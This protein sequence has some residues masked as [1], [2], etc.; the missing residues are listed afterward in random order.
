MTS[1]FFRKTKAKKI[2]SAFL[3]FV[4]VF[5]MVQCL[6]LGS[7]AA[8]AD[9]RVV[10]NSTMDDWKNYFGENVLSTQNA[11]KVWTD[12]S[13]LKEGFTVGSGANEVT[14]SLD[15]QDN[16]SF[17]VVLS[18][19]ASNAQVTGKTSAPLDTMLVL[20]VSGS[21]NNNS[22]NNDAVEDLVDAANAAAKKLFEA[23][24]K[25]RVGVVL[26]SSSASVLLPLGSYTTASDDNYFNY[27]TRG[28]D[29]Y[30]SVDSDVRV[31]GT[32]T[33]PSANTTEVVGA[34]YVQTGIHLAK[35]QFVAANNQTTVDG[36]KRQPVMI[37]MSDGNPT[38]STTEYTNPGSHNLGN[39]QASSTSAA[40]GFVTQLTAAYA[41]QQVKE[42][43]G[44][45]L[46]LYTLGFKVT[47]GS[48]AESVLNPDESTTAI[49]DL[50][51]E[52]DNAAVGG[53]VAIERSGEWVN[54]GSFWNPNYEYV[55]T[56][57]DVVKVDG[58][59][60]KYVD[61]YFSTSSSLTDAFEDIVSE[62][63]LQAKYHPTLV[64]K[65]EDLDGYV[66]FVDRIGKYMD[67]RD[68]KGILIGD[69]LFS[70]ADIASNFETNGGTAGN[71]HIAA[72]MQRLKIDDED[73]VK[74]LVS[75]AMNDNQ[76]Y[77]NSTT[78]EYSNYIGWYANAQG[79][80]LGY[81]NEGTTVLPEATGDVNTDPA[82]VV[83]SYGYLGEVDKE[84]GVT[85]SDMMFVTVQ[86]RHN[87]KTGEELVTFA[88]PA[89]LIPIVTYDVTLDENDELENLTVSGAEAPIRLI[90]EVGLS[91]KVNA[92][93][94]HDPNV[95]DPAYLA[96]NENVDGTVNFY[97]NQYEVDGSVGYGKVNT[98]SYFNPA[99]QNDRYY[100][101]EDTLIY[102]DTNGTVYTGAAAPSGST[103]YRGYTVYAKNGSFQ[104]KTEYEPISEYSLAKAKSNGD[105]T[106]S[107]PKGIVHTFTE[108]LGVYKN[109]NR[110]QTLT[111]AQGRGIV[112]IPF[113]DTTGHEV[114]ESGYYFYVGATLGNN[115]KLTVTPATGIRLSKTVEGTQTNELFTFT[116]TGSNADAGRT[117]PATLF[118]GVN[119]SAETSVTF[120]AS[121]IAQ[122]SLKHGQSLFITG[123]T[124]DRTYTITENETID[125]IVSTVNGAPALKAEV[126]IKENELANA[127]F[128]NI[129]R[130]KGDLTITKEVHHNLGGGYTINPDKKFTVEVTLSGIG[131]A[132]KNFNAEHSAIGTTSVTTDENGK[133]TIT[134]AHDE[135]IEI[136]D[137]PVGTKAN[138]KETGYVAAFTPEYMVNGTVTG[139]AADGANATVAS[140]IVATVIITNDY[141]PDPVSHPINIT[142]G[143]S[144]V[145]QGRDWQ[146]SDVFTFRF[147]KYDAAS[148][149]WN[150]VIGVDDVSVRGSD[151]Q[152]TFEFANAFQNEN[153]TALGTYYYR[154][155]EVIPDERIGGITYDRTVHSFGVVVSDDLSGELKI[156][157]VVP[158]RPSTVVA[159]NGDAWEVSAQFTNVYSTTG[160]ATVS[161]DITKAINNPTNSP[162]ATSAGYKFEVLDNSG[163][164]IYTS[165]ETTDRG[166]TRVVMTFDSLGKNT[167]TL[168]EF[169]PAN[170]PDTMGYDTHTLEFTVEITDNGHGGYAAVIYKGTTAPAGATDRISETFTNS[171]LPKTQTADLYISADKTLTG[172]DMNANEF[173]FV[174]HPHGDE[175]TILATGKNAA[176]Q[177]GKSATITFDK[178]LTFNKVGIYEF[179]MGERVEEKNGLT[180]DKNHYHIV[181]TVTDD[182]GQLKSSYT[183]ANTADN[184]I[185]FKN[186][187]KAKE[188]T[189]TI[190]G[191]K[192]LIGKTLVNDEFTF[193]LKEVDENANDF[194]GAKVYE[195]K[196]FADGTFSFETISYT[197][198]GEYYYKVYEKQ[199]SAVG[200]I[201]FDKTEYFVT[202]KVTDDKLGSLSASETISGA[203]AISFTNTYKA[204]A[205]S[206]TVPGDKVLTGKT[207]S[208]GDYTFELYASNS[209]WAQG[210]LIEGDVKNDASGTF[211]FT[212]LGTL[213][214]ETSK[215][216]FTEAGSYYYLVKEKNGGTEIDGVFYDP[217]VYR[218]L[219]VVTDDLEGQLHASVHTYTA[220]GIPTDLIF[221][222]E[223]HVVRGKDIEISGTKSLNK[224]TLRDAM[225]D[226]AIYSANANF[227]KT[228]NTPLDTVSN[229]G[230]S[231]KFNISYT[232]DDI[233][234]GTFYYVVEEVNAGHRIDGITYST[235][236]FN[237]EV[238]VYDNGDGNVGTTINIAN[239]PIVFTNVYTADAVS[240]T[241][242]G[243]KNVT[244]MNLS[245]GAFTFELYASDENW[246]QGA[247]IEGDVKNDAN[248]DFTF[249]KLGTYN[250]EIDKWEF[251]QTGSYYYLVKEKDGGSEIRGV[252]YD[253]EVYKVRIDITDN[254][255]GK[256]EKSV[257]VFKSNGA[258]S[259]LVFNNEYRIVRG[260][261]ATFGGTKTLRG[262]TLNDNM[263]EFELFEA[264]S[265]FVKKSATAK[266]SVF[267]DGNSFEFTVDYTPADLA[268]GKFYY[269]IEEKNAGE[270]IKGITYSRASY[271]VIVTITDGGDGSIDTDVDVVN[272][273]VTFTNVYTADAVSATIEG[274]KQL[275]DK[276]LKA[277][278]FTF[279]LYAA[280]EYWTQGA[281]VEG[282]VKNDADGNFTFTKLGTLNATTNMYEF[283]EAGSYYYIVREKNGGS[284]IDGVHYD[285]SVYKVRVDITDDLEG[286]LHKAV[287]VYDFGGN[288]AELVFKNEYK[289]VRGES[290]EITGNKVLTEGTLEDN[291]FEFE[292]FEA[293]ANF[294]KASDTPVD[295]VSNTGDSFKITLDYEPGD[296]A[297]GKFYY[298]VSEK[299]AGQKINDIDYSTATFNVIVTVSDGGNGKVQTVVDVVNGPI[300]FTNVYN[301]I[302]EDIEVTIGV[303]KSV[304]NKGSEKIGPDGF[305]FVLENTTLNTKVNLRTD[306]DGKIDFALKFTANDIGKK[307]EYKLYETNE[308]KLGVT[309]SELVYKFSIEVTK[310]N[311]KLYAYLSEN[312]VAVSESRYEFKNVYDY[313]PTPSTPPTP[314]GPPAPD[315]GD[316]NSLNFWMIVMIL[317]LGAVLTLSL[318]SKKK[319]KANQ[320]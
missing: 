16:E 224:V 39:G 226:F 169:V 139:N 178:P 244:N 179:D 275:K 251:T 33:R 87:I 89:A 97:S 298:V 257:N 91:D 48:I 38:Y 212:K 225:F 177:D 23:N 151:A 277:G 302:P 317:S 113:V 115:G 160:T 37:V 314:P 264:D 255:G 52:W 5:S 58:L 55:E 9:T 205:T 238:E 288:G 248:G 188:T 236:K 182:G 2:L 146:N 209:S 227:E 60:Q 126:T 242:D 120:D 260:D 29:E 174:L 56:T 116:I 215:Y 308:G 213:N 143:G 246:T 281:L 85:E 316:A 295:T 131:T 133:F 69:H 20:D 19:I 197:Q 47:D 125:Y 184:T 10:D 26:Y 203:N 232:P 216:E 142:V 200:G 68:M 231:F 241:I 109:P 290:A 186:T 292:L 102:T 284:E 101:T 164:V 84:H 176:A 31:A 192:T 110:T 318:T 148:G 207:L 75:L 127:A 92:L 27:T 167:Y 243:E 273:P 166:F 114:D 259:E 235:A 228:S 40:Q 108:G 267:N 196:N 189:H 320:R 266:K 41:K 8:T 315:T 191:S 77:Y 50:W 65:S 28:G 270:R 202:V 22:G 14:I 239:G 51:V 107:V 35:E 309:Y 276:D 94:L 63:L 76:L 103:F 144:K 230:D 163:Q 221:T 247:L 159:K 134:L 78:G 286:K 256:L 117:Y 82:F 240:A 306:K 155:V 34:T 44:S 136:F 150:K 201:T 4:M 193:V 171:Y 83:R 170:Y 293:D 162:N 289:V 271:K 95:V 111:D 88:V 172:R 185:H 217:S 187:Y 119:E 25:N 175:D 21:M 156:T 71:E 90:Y 253:D 43:Y 42:K 304:E 250:N 66:S 296:I 104:T 106:W 99:K 138:I 137:L 237:V 30:I 11:G 165:A 229:T 12:K 173:T 161:I 258:V 158:Y 100:Y 180:I 233:A 74:T 219:V 105:G 206:A 254:L 18:A 1:K 310:E 313:T 154:V 73:V 57:T 135:K 204:A 299:N 222:N 312:P 141:D 153:L 220:N 70:G 140:D 54:T 96:A 49:N 123:M 269:V 262:L 17:L 210:A 36:V 283:T 252:F 245:A 45:D 285:N 67:V 3:S 297:V 218:V 307:F 223:Y 129:E 199:Q 149:T 268:T 112:N 61:K 121:G 279:E 145:L 194:N 190:K 300:V 249:T 208:A 319:E 46:L 195:A 86:V 81:Y 263:F 80:Y 98:Y 157:D 93:T 13:V 234:T 198:A 147:E 6:T 181:V 261:S 79:A 64:S 128:V 130:G 291:M 265:N 168:R 132:D 287:T 272:G 15:S 62:A 183:V 152:K 278:D 122:V 118:D 274:K 303:D 32:S 280:D 7:F 124:K 72:I 311:H 294:N 305:E 59:S 282:D 211:T 301:P 53:N 214:P 24:D